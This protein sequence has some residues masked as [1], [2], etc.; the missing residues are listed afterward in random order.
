[1]RYEY[2]RLGDMFDI[3]KYWVYGKNKAW[4]TRLEHPTINSVPVISGVTINNGENYYTED[5]YSD[6][7]V[8]E[9]CLTISTRGEYSGT[10]FYH[11][12]KFVLANNILA[13]PMFG[14]SKN[15][16]LYLAA[17]I[18]KLGYGGYGGYPKKDTLKNDKIYLPIKTD[19]NSSPII[20]TD[21]KYHKD[22]YIPDFEYMERY[23][24][25]LEQERIAELE[26]ERIAELEQY[27]IA[28]GLNDYTLTDE[29]KQVLSLIEPSR[30]NEL[31]D[32]ADVG[33]VPKQDYK[34]FVIGELFVKEN[35]KWRAKRKFNKKL[36]ISQ[37]MSDE[38]NLPLCN[39]KFGNNGIMYYGRKEDWDFVSGGID[40][41]ND[42]AIS[43]GSV[44]PQP[45]D[46][47]VLYNAYIVTVKDRN[48]NQQILEFLACVLEK[49]I[50]H[51][52]GY[53]LKASWDRVR[54]DKI[55]L[56]IQTDKNN[57]PIIDHTC[58]YHK[59][60]YIPDF[61]FMERYIKA[62]EKVVI[63]DVVKYK[64]GV[65]EQTKALVNT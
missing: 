11:D 6:K 30:C 62:M 65:I 39:A 29:D 8:F 12:G 59:D 43:T 14:L 32:R 28:T 63:A 53:E 36:D 18:N 54:N 7:E 37:C 22:G 31:A 24:A 58:K 49:A 40:I 35:L 1:M 60:G 41:V 56:P 45:H 10:V 33:A 21:C 51:K 17:C 15:V 4:K 52:Y 48:C 25:E 34:E 23:I 46:I 50:K 2:F 38:F 61:A 26:Q 19:E 9:D 55:V 44:Y 20:D 13:M 3:D 42:G 16:K 64:D 47:G 27:L 5:N 57:N